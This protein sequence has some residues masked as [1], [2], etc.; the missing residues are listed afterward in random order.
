MSM[1][2]PTADKFSFHDFIVVTLE[3]SPGL[4]RLLEQS[5]VI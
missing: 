2:P 1:Y 3:Q 5:R 4:H